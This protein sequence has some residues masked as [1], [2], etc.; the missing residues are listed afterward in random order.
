MYNC[1]GKRKGEHGSIFQCTNT[2]DTPSN[3]SRPEWGFLCPTCSGIQYGRPAIQLDLPDVDHPN[4]REFEPY[5]MHHSGRA[6]LKSADDF[7]QTEQEEL[8]ALNE[9]EIL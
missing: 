2:S 7:E 5:E 1:I 8:D 9:L 4:A 6:G 3:P